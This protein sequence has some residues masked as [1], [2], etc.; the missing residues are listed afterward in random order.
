MWSLSLTGGR[1][2]KSTVKTT[3]PS[4]VVFAY[5]DIGVRCLKALVDL[6]FD[7][8][9]V[10]THQDRPSEEIWFDSV[11]LTAE[12]YEIPVITPEDPNVAQVEEQVRQAGADFLFSFYYRN[13]LGQAMLDASRRG[14]F[15]VHGSLLPKYRGRVPVNWAVLHGERRCGVTL[16]RMDIKPDAGNIVAQVSVPV[17]TNDTAFDVFQK[18]KCAAESLILHSVPKLVDGSFTETPQELSKGRYFTGRKP[19]DGRIDWSLPAREIH[20]LVRAVAPP[21]PGAFFHHEGHRVE[22]LGSLFRG[23]KALSQ[24]ACIYVDQG[25][26]WADC[27][28]G[29]RFS[30]QGKGIG[31]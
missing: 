9:L 30:A 6:N 20:N 2:L 21:F 29:H 8:R 31:R 18:L 1:G 16:H 4:A 3:R 17:L 23:E 24:R 28:D 27:Q 12:H 5:H 25:V 14:A 22:I 19:E 13:L 26:F 11:A 10:V 7:V 15:N